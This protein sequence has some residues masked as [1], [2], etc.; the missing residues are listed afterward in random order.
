LS[1]LA[2]TPRK[3]FFDNL[4]PD[5][6]ERFLDNVPLENTRFIVVS[7]SG[8]TGET[9]V[10]TIAVLNALD[11]AGHGDKI[12]HYI[13]GLSE[14]AGD[15][16]NPLRD[17]LEPLGVTFLEHHKGVGGRFSVLTNV[18]LLP[19]YLN[20]VDIHAIRK[21]AEEALHAL[22]DAGSP[23][24]APAA[25]GAALNVAAM[26]AGKNISVMLGYADKLER[27]TAWWVQLWAESL[28]K[29]GQGTTPVRNIGPVDQHSQ[30]Q[31]HLA[32]PRDKLFTVITVGVRGTG[33]VIDEN[34]AKKAGLDGFGGRT[35]GDLVSVQ[36]Q[37]TID[38]LAKNGCPVRHIHIDKLD[39]RALGYLLMH[40]MLE[41]VIAA[42]LMGVDAYDQ[43]AVEEGKVLAKR[44]LQQL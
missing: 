23:D 25:V 42:D 7:K 15:K 34:H 6:L 44:Y 31:L 3:H 5:T 22:L 24:L 8:G 30:L 2:T 1:G 39:E 37:A 27:F 28:G 10:Q 33:P 41:T 40:F 29:D 4:D 38:T 17:L 35:V 16:S 11:A 32:G 18:G 19:A 36:G 26:K 20:G 12:A 9:L 21:G 14:P 13:L 43:P